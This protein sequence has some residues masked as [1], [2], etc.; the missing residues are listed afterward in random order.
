MFHTRLASSSPT[1][2]VLAVLAAFS[3]AACASAPVRHS[4]PVD[5][6]WYNGANKAGGSSRAMVSVEPNDADRVRVGVVEESALQLGDLWRASIWLAAFQAS[7]AI[8]RPLSDW[9]ISVELDHSGRG[10]DGPS[11]GALLTAGM[12]AGMTG[13][14]IDPAFTMTGTI[15]P[16]GTIGPVSGIPQ[17]FRAAIAGGK[18]VLGFPLGQITDTDLVTG[19]DVSVP[20]LAEGTGAVVR[21]VPDI[22]TAYELMTGRSLAR[23]KALA[24]EAMALPDRVKATLVEQTKSWFGSF[25]QNYRNYVDLRVEDPV[26]KAWWSNIDQ[27]FGVALAAFERGELVAAWFESAALFVDA[28][29]ALVRANLLRRLRDARYEDAVAYVTTVMG[30][31]DQRLVDLVA[32]LKK[33]VARSTSELMTL[34]DA[35]EAFGSAVRHF[36]AALQKKNENAQRVDAI[37]A[38]LRQKTIAWTPEV[39]AE[40]V[41][42][43]MAPAR[44]VS[45][46]NVNAFICSQNLGFRPDVKPGAREVDQRWIDRLGKLFGTAG[47]TNLSYFEALVIQSIAD[48]NEVSL[49]KVRANFTDESY[50]LVR[51]GPRGLMESILEDQFGAGTPALSLVRLSTAVNTYVAASFLIAK[52]YSLNASVGDGGAITGIG[53]ETVLARMLSLAS[54]KALE[55]AARARQLTGEV[56]MASRI[57]F[58][59]ATT[60]AKRP[61]LQ[62][63][64]T[65]LEQF[66]RA[67]MFSQMAVLLKR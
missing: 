36:S 25:E 47:N 48:A 55:H 51:P 62:A 37:I 15:N 28:D 35:F 17:K 54:E 64:L 22:E 52:Y 18:R 65:A 46:S 2:P 60:L 6:L 53:R 39:E 24:P 8:A 31:V 4:V 26:L 59:A 40:L 19:K 45:L 41:G 27:A 1:S 16:D 67:S 32:V 44:D 5:V 10:M 11:A 21:E 3:V 14:K 7:L 9:F 50:Q 43:L 42:L 61:A 66:W 56:P 23:P 20:G 38:G 34:V 29:T 12:L 49:D 58:D 33:D 63:R 57:A 30:N 13:A